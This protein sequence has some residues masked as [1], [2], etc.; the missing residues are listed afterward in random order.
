VDDCAR[1]HSLAAEHGR[2]GARYV[3]CGASLRSGDALRLVT[4]VTGRRTRTVFLP[5][6]AMVAGATVVEV[7]ARAVGRTPPMCRE[8]AT[9]AVHGHRYDGSRATRDLGLRYVSVEETV[10]RTLAWFRSEGL[11]PSAGTGGNGPSVGSV[12]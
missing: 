10:R 9:A 12:R 3:L 7:A 8:L 6:R 5:G 2:R 11:L 4:S 1:G